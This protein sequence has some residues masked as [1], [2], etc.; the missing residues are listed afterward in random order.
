MKREILVLLMVLF[1]TYTY[2][3]T[4]WDGPNITFTKPN[5]ADHT[6]E[7][8][9]DRIT[10]NVWITRGSSKGIFNIK[11]EAAYSGSGTSGNSPIDTEWAFGTTNN[12]ETLTF[13]T[14][15]VAM[16]KSPA[17]QVNKDMVVHLISDNIYIDIKFLSWSNFN[18]GAGFSYQR[19]SDPSLGVDRFSN[20]KFS[21]SP[22]PNNSEIRLHFPSPATDVSVNIY[23]ILG[24]KI[25]SSPEYKA[26]INV[27]SWSKGIYLVQVNALGNTITKRFIKN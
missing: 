25:Y 27:L 11:Q 15:A 19:S 12:I 4:I 2:A 22:N 23:N 16:D 20:I 7:V 13:T 14:W 26:P 8:N 3:Q 1:S 6:L 17:S 21:I 10:S 18:N 5:N 24:K 9:Q